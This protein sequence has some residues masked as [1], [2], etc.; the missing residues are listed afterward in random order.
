MQLY[1]ILENSTH[2]FDVHIDDDD[3]N[4]DDGDDISALMGTTDDHRLIL[5]PHEQS[6]LLRVNNSREMSTGTIDSAL[7]R[8]CFS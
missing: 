1:F 7:R 3:D 4:D 2:L 8:S 6:H 5:E